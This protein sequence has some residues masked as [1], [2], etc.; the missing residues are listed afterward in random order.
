MGFGSNQNYLKYALT[1]DGS[2]DTSEGGIIRSGGK[3]IE[4]NIVLSANNTTVN[5]NLFQ[6]SGTLLI[7]GLH[8]EVIDVTTLSNMTEVYFDLWDGTNSVPITK[9]T[10]AAMSG[11]QVGGFFI[12]DYDNTTALTTI[13]NDQCRVTEAPASNKS[14]H[15]FLITQKRNTNTY[16]R[17]NYTTTDAPIN[18]ALKIDIVYVD[19][20]N[21]LIT[22]I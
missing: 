20:D 4:M 15:E 7:K 11:F 2:D 3:H 5:V 14:F 13:N 9:T 12:K 16:L 8:G 18:A 1:G 10:G 19:I 17:L 22:A 6:I 21:G